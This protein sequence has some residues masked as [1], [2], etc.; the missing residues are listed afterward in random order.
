MAEHKPLI[1]V[2]DVRKRYGDVEA[3]KGISFSIGPGEICGYLGPNGAGKSTTVKILTGL[4]RPDAGWARVAGYD[5]ALQPVEAKRR[6]GYVPETAALFEALTAYEYLT[7]VGGLHGLSD[8]DLRFRIGKF[9]QLF[10]LGAEASQRMSGYSKGMRQKVAIA[11]A[12]L[13]DPPV[14]LLDEPLNGLDANAAFMVKEILRNLA[15][16]GKA[17]LFCSHVLEVVERLCDRVVILDRGQIVADGPMERIK[18]T[19]GLED[20]FRRLTSNED[21]T[22]VAEGFLRSLR[23]GPR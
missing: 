10:Q 23:E 22:A 18:A 15:R 12:L 9:L 1:Q 2:A 8:R 17:V 21:L 14:V 16:E 4:L 5:P 3:L 19:A 6:L 7:F 20:F 11:A 13:H